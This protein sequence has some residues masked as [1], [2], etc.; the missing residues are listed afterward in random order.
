MESK[1]CRTVNCVI[2]VYTL[3]GDLGP[4]SIFRV[5][6]MILQRILFTKVWFNLSF[7]PLKKGQST[8]VNMRLIFSFCK[9]SLNFGEVIRPNWT[10]KSIPIC[11]LF[12]VFIFVI[13]I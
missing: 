2:I 8:A 6:I 1:S 3:Y 5:F 7:N 13:N 4:R 11:A 9:N 10:A 12:S